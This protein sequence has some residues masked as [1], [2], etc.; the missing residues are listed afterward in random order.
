VE[1]HKPKPVHS[2]RELLTEI[3]VVVIGVCI[4][5]GAEQ[6]VEWLH[7]RAQVSDAREVIA[8]ELVA[9]IQGGIIIQRAE[10]CTERRL[11]QLAAILDGAGKSGSL[12]PVGDIGFPPRGLW[13]GNGAW[14]S[15]VASQT[16]THFPS[17]QLAHISSLY[18][19][20]QRVESF[21]LREI[22][23]WRDLYAMIGPGR[24]LD[25]PSE[26]ALRQ[27]LSN[28]RHDTRVLASLGGAVMTLV[29]GTGISFSRQD[30]AAIADAENQPLTE[31][32]ANGPQLAVLCGPIG[33]VPATYGQATLG[34][35]RATYKGAKRTWPDFSNGAQ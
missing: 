25:A 17:Q 4:A 24:R 28:A 29:K 33:A 26:A 7:W 5:L 16:A 8:T 1:I 6:T 14:E 9:S 18:K 3:G 31:V 34:N 30:L 22:Q 27:T 32:A 35:V 20:I 13:W 2:W 10:S 15:V 19:M 12:P 23:D 11:D 21:D